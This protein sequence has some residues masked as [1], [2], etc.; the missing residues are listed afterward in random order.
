MWYTVPTMMTLEQYEQ[1]LNE[2]YQGSLLGV[3]LLDRLSQLASDDLEE[4]VVVEQGRMSVAD[5]RLRIYK[6][7]G[8]AS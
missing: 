6:T 3:R 8:R 5:R 1:A 2:Q 4:P 7:T